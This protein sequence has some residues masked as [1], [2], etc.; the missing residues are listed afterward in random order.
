[1]RFTNVLFIFICLPSLAMA[2]QNAE[3]KVAESVELFRVAMVDANAKTLDELS[4]TQL[5]YGHSAGLV[6]DKTEFIRRLTSGESD[7]IT[8]QLS[9]QSLFISGNTAIVR[10][11]LDAKT[12]DNGKPGQV[13]LSVLMVW[14]K[15]GKHWKLLARQAVKIV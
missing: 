14:Q 1:M 8:I 11:Q 9:N 2:Q 5:S 3:K 15:H 6:E 13:K 10:H 4:A 12:N 7:F